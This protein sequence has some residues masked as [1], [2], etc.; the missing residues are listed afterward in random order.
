VRTVLTT[1]SGAPGADGSTVFNASTIDDVA[2]SNSPIRGSVVMA[3]SSS[4]GSLASL[5][6]VI[7]SNRGR[8]DKLYSGVRDDVDKLTD[9]RMKQKKMLSDAGDVD[10]EPSS[11][12]NHRSTGGKPNAAAGSDRHSKP[13]MKSSKGLIPAADRQWSAAEQL[14]Q[15]TNELLED[16][17]SMSLLSDGLYSM[18]N[19]EDDEA[20]DYHIVDH[21]SAAWEVVDSVD[22]DPEL[23]RQ[24]QERE[25]VKNLV[26]AIALKAK[27]RD[28]GVAGS[29]GTSNSESVLPLINKYGNSTTNNSIISPRP[30]ENVK[31][32]DI[33]NSGKGNDVG[34][35]FDNPASYSSA[36]L[37]PSRPTSSKS[38][39]SSAPPSRPTSSA[40]SSS[41]SALQSHPRTA[42]TTTSATASPAPASSGPQDDNG[43]DFQHHRKDVDA[44]IQALTEHMET[45][46]ANSTRAV[47]E[48]E[49]FAS[50]CGDEAS[51]DVIGD[52]VSVS[53]DVKATD[54]PETVATAKFVII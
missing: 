31:F 28:S 20:D 26:S 17:Q 52:Y 24:K 32:P 1:V 15:R 7:S 50:Q 19:D 13:S 21:E 3:P 39:G 12:S 46:L 43:E 27:A 14:S 8:L 54:E 48:G 45:V 6:S 22:T 38:S 49:V 5:Q 34:D 16:Y 9:L 4:A 10:S 23:Q 11:P 25:R 47:I 36:G 30:P 53:E 33:R 37:V 35:V 2:S 40:A 42:W 18:G 44:R 29:A 51:E 41:S